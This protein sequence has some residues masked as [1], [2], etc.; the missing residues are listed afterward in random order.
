MDTLVF[1]RGRDATEE[2][3]LLEDGEP[4]DATPVTRIQVDLGATVVDSQ[5]APAAF[6][7]PVPL[8][9]KRASGERIEVQGMRLNLAKSDLAAGQYVGQLVIYDASHPNG[10]PWE[11]V[12]VK[13]Y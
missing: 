5:T 1:Y 11:W 6:E 7:W 4:V 9:F 12:S 10:L 8:T 13:L 3:V 2:L